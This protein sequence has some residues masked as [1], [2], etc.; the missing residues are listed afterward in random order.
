LK[1]VD[2]SSSQA[3]QKLTSINTASAS[4]LLAQLKSSMVAKYGA[5]EGD[6]GSCQV[7][8]AIL[9]HRILNARQHLILYPMDQRAAYNLNLLLS[10][11]RSIL[12]Y[13]KRKEFPSYERMMNDFGITEREL[14]WG[15][16]NKTLPGGHR[17][18]GK[19][20]KTR[21]KIKRRKQLQSLQ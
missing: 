10:R 2:T 8:I 11:R 3:L 1:E 18:K 4:E 5:F 15:V 19:S 14:I 21:M 9:S 12:L 16:A 17:G 13:L 20:K 6:T 7:Q